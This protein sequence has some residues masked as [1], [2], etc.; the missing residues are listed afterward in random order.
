MY[1]CQI[2]TLLIEK[3]I[4]LWRLKQKPLMLLLLS[5][6]KIIEYFVIRYAPPLPAYLDVLK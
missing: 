2:S 1:A 3:R 6:D 5:F 4:E